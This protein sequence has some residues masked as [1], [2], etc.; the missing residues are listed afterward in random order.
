[1]FNLD[2]VTLPKKPMLMSLFLTTDTYAKILARLPSPWN[3]DKNLLISPQFLLTVEATA[4]MLEDGYATVSYQLA[5]SWLESTLCRLIV[6]A[7]IYI[8]HEE[9]DVHA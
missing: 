6:N 2:E 4:K 8:G 7:A 1:M 9:F 3:I 5:T